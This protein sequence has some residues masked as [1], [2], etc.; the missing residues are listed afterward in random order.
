VEPNPTPYLR[1]MQFSEMDS[2]I[3][4]QLVGEW[5]LRDA[6]KQLPSNLFMQIKDSGEVYEGTRDIDVALIEGGRKLRVGVESRPHH[7]IFEREG[8]GLGGYEGVWQMWAEDR[9]K[10]LE[11]EQWRADGRYIALFDGNDFAF[12]GK[13]KVENDRLTSYELTYCLS[14]IADEIF[15]LFCLTGGVFTCTW[16]VADGKM[17][18]V[19]EVGK[20]TVWEKVEPW[21]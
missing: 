20:E 10:L 21:F 15:Q 8:N 19:D 4:P 5:Q 2:E 17:H 1:A 14:P 9:R 13:F 11:E 18:L 6:E 3:N 7:S 12:T 16:H